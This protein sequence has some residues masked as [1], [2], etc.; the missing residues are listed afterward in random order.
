MADEKAKRVSALIGL[1]AAHSPLSAVAQQAV[2]RECEAGHVE[3]ITEALAHALLQ[4]GLTTGKIPPNTG[5]KKEVPDV[6]AACIHAVK[7]YADSGGAL[8]ARGWVESWRLAAVMLRQWNADFSPEIPV[9]RRL[10]LGMPEQEV[11]DRICVAV[12]NCRE[13]FLELVEPDEAFR[14]TDGSGIEAYVC[15]PV[16]KEQLETLLS[17]LVKAALEAFDDPNA[18]NHRLLHKPKD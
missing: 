12:L 15:Y 13:K 16:A 6:D 4:D 7:T 9:S 10:V 17:A 18:V 1:F 5:K 3:E 2:I 8:M 14:G 11:A